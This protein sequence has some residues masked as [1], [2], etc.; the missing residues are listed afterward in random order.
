MSRLDLNVGHSEE[1]IDKLAKQGL[2]INKSVNIDLPQL[3]SDIS[4]ISD[5]ELMALFSQLTAFT[6]F[7]TTQLSCAE[8]DERRAEKA[9]NAVED[10]A[11]IRE[12]SGKSTKDT[13]TF[14]KTKISTDPQVVKF[15]ESY[16]SK[17]AYRKLIDSMV[18]NASRDSMLVSRE[19]TRRTAGANA[20]T[21]GQRM[22][23]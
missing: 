15:R 12:H 6:N 17:Y 22:F 11:M 19:L 18:D 21:R 1:Y 8:I 4:A 13:V 16:E 2:V 10:E 3:P 23:A 5:G 9:L 7:L 14:L 20:S